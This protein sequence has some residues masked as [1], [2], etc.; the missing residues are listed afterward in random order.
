[1]NSKLIVGKQSLVD[2]GVFGAETAYCDIALELVLGDVFF[3]YVDSNLRS[4]LFWEMVDASADARKGN[5]FEPMLCS[6]VERGAVAGGKQL[7]LALIA[8]VPYRTNSVY[9]FLHGRL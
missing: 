8:T 9:D 1:M 4:P 6:N 5:A 3:N 7:V 2:V